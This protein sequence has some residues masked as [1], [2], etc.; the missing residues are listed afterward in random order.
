M[1]V[2]LSFF[3]TMRALLKALRIKLV[4]RDLSFKHLLI[5]AYEMELKNDR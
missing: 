4:Y 1:K 5:T 3:T 2:K